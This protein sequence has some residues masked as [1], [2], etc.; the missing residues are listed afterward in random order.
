MCNNDDGCDDDDDDDD[1]DD[2]SSGGIKLLLP[3]CI[4]FIS[5]GQIKWTFVLFQII[6]L[7]QINS[8]QRHFY[9]DTRSNSQMLLFEAHFCVYGRINELREL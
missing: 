7:F 6:K 3:L 2:G 4:T 8:N 9:I 1:D 5:C